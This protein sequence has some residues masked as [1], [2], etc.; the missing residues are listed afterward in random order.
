GRK[1]LLWLRGTY[2]AYTD[3]QQQVLMQILA[4]GGLCN[5]RRPGSRARSCA[6][7]AQRGVSRAFSWARPS[8]VAAVARRPVERARAV[9]GA[10]QPARPASPALAEGAARVVTRAAPVAR[11]TG[12]A[13]GGAVAGTGGGGG[14]G[15]SGVGGAGAAGAGGAGAGGSGGGGTAGDGGTTAGR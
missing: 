9:R 4:G 5:A 11:E 7:G 8:P 13:A 14:V 12:A 10:G 6:R 3:Y 15:A 2:R 1:V